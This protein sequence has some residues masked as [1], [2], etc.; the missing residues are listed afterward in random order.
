MRPIL[1]LIL[2]QLNF[3]PTLNPSFNSHLKPNITQRS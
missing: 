2:P 1:T 3:V